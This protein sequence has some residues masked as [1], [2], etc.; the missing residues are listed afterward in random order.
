ME[1]HNCVSYVYNTFR[2]PIT[3]YTDIHKNFA[4]QTQG[5]IYIRDL[6]SRRMDNIEMKCVNDKRDAQFL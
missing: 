5:M 2:N 4:Q 6:N 1:L 3:L